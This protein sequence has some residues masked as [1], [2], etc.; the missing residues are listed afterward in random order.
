MTR[1]NFPQLYDVTL[2]L[3][4]EQELQAHKCVLISRLEYFSMMF[5]HSWAEKDYV[6]LQSISIEYMQPIIDFL[7]TNTIEDV[8]YSD[9]YMYNMIKICDQFFVTELKNMFELKTSEKISV[10]NCGEILEF[11]DT[12]N[13]ETLRNCCMQF[14]SLNF[15]RILELKSLE[16]TDPLVLQQINKF[17]RQFF[18]LVSYWTITPYANAITDEALEQFVSDFSVDLKGNQDEDGTKYKQKHKA[19]KPSKSFLDKRNY[20]KV[21]IIAM[22][23]MSYLEGEKAEDDQKLK[24]QEFFD[25]MTILTE[26]FE[27]EAK[28]WTKVNDK[29]ETKKKQNSVLTAL[30]VNDVLRT[31]S[32]TGNTFTCLKNTPPKKQDHTFKNAN[33]RTPEPSTSKTTQAPLDDN[34]PRTK[35]TFTIADITPLKMK[36]SQKNRKK[37]S[38]GLVTAN[39]RNLFDNQ[40]VPSVTPQNPWKTLPVSDS[41]KSPLEFKPLKSNTTLSPSQTPKSFQSIVENEKRQKQYYEKIKTKSLAL[42]QLEEKAIEEL[43]EFYNV[44][45]IYDETISIERR[46]VSCDDNRVQC[47]KWYQE[48]K[49]LN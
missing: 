37:M 3:D 11:A 31:E 30:K 39:P 36:S 41:M 46:K 40:D 21:G 9:N 23:E 45:N 1:T 34:S 49:V 18:S 17:Y 8:Q 44:E 2:K 38:P 29:K 43:Q 42:T 33:E 7:Y 48:K 27:S 15:S 47:T 16:S 28:L 13:C 4:C 26:K 5:D 25:E 20:E 35:L 19:A 6:N 14:I 12:Y 22:Q 32:K 10:K 24:Q